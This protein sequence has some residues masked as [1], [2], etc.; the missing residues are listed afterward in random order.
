MQEFFSK[1]AILPHHG[2]TQESRGD[3]TREQ[4]DAFAQLLANSIAGMFVK[5]PRQA[6]LEALFKYYRFHPR[7]LEIFQDRSEKD[8]D[9]NV[10]N[11]ALEKLNKFK[12]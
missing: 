4:E 9:E 12:D 1:C 5:N 11:F 3:E 8:V 7:T 2:I 6:A 10:R